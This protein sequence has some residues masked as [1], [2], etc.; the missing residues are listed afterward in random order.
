MRFAYA[1]IA[2]CW[3]A[4]YAAWAMLAIWF[5]SGG[6]R[7]SPALAIGVLI[8]VV[9]LIFGHRL[10]S[11]IPIPSP[12]ARAAA[13]LIAGSVLCVLGVTCAIWARVTLG[14]NW[15]M[16]MTV[17]KDPELVTSGPYRYVRH[18]IYTGLSA[19]L[20]GATLVL[21]PV[22]P[23][24]L[25]VA[26][27]CVVSAIREERDMERRFPEAYPAYRRRSKMFLPFLI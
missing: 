9:A 6:G 14:R 23:A 8:V 21:P 10:F 2:V 16:P 1:V 13:W 24:A 20:A 5:R 3:L 7:R 11:R 4:F 12:G 22:A 17:H 25:L 15:G 27:Y 26:I 19:M 18:P